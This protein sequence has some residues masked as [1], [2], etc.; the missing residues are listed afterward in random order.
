[1][2]AR[3]PMRRGIPDMTLEEIRSRIDKRVYIVLA[4]KEMWDYRQCVDGVLSGRRDCMPDEPDPYDLA[5]SKRQ[6]ERRVQRWR[7]ELRQR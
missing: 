2:A 6:W 5:L 3:L 1:M 4:I 7:A